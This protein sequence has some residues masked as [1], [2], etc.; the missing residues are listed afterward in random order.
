MRVLTRTEVSKIKEVRLVTDEGNKMISATE[1][2][3]MAEQQGLDLVLFSLDGSI[4]PVVKIQD[5]KR[6]RFQS[7]KKKK[8]KKTR[9]SVLKEVQLKVNISDHDLETKKK[10]IIKFLTRGDKV[11]IVIKLKG[12]ERDHP[13]RARELLTKVVT[14]VECKHSVIP[15]PMTIAILEKA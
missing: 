15:G 4:P 11:K 7:Q 3:S 12:R 1:A 10:N 9:A 8:S 14:T 6:I 5:Y 13:E 2:F